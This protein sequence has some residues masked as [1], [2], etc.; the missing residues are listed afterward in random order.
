MGNQLSENYD[1][2]HVAGL[3]RMGF[4]FLRSLVGFEF[5]PFHFVCFVG[6]GWRWI[7]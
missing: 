2:F 5:P 1:H 3:R 6:L 7:G 4:M